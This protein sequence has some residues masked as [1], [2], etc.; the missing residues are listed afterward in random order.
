MK[1]INGLDL[2]LE[3]EK[4][5]DS[6]LKPTALILSGVSASWE[7]NSIKKTLKNISLTIHPG[8]FIGVAGLVGAGKVIIFNL[9]FL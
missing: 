2:K 7:P 1:N 4:N 8:E 5:R 9:T 6:K 3:K